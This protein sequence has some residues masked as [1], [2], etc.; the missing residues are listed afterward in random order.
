V[1]K[2][3]KTIF[4]ADNI[5]ERIVRDLKAI[6]DLNDKLKKISSELREFGGKSLVDKDLD[7]ILKNTLERGRMTANY[8]MKSIKNFKKFKQNLEKK[9]LQ[10]SGKLFIIEPFADLN[11]KSVV[12]RIG[13]CYL[14]PE[15][16]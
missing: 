3:I 16:V 14:L 12:D 4:F 1:N 5:R 13:D 8:R 9:F 10:S 7:E 15:M 6:P 11:E 2:F